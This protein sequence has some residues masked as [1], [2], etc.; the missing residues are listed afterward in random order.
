MIKHFAFAAAAALA[1]GSLAPAFADLD[2]SINTNQ[3][4]TGYNTAEILAAARALGMTATAQQLSDGTEV[5]K[6]QTPDV[7]FFAQ[8][9]VCN[10]TTCTG[11]AIYAQYN[12]GFDL[13]LDMFNE[14]NAS[15]A[16]V[17][18]A[19]VQ[20]SAVLKRYLIGDYGEYLGNI[21]SD[22]FNFNLRAKAFVDFANGGGKQVSY[23]VSAGANAGARAPLRWTDDAADDDFHLKIRAEMDNAASRPLK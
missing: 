11:L 4:V 3:A 19:K 8:R 18:V 22:L 14:F 23:K 6:F 10:Q 12:P 20:N 5:L 17:S 2:G 16:I 15:Q 21:A 9:T 13:P 1:L 7:V